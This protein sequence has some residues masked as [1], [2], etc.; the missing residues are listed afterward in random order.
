[1]R[2]AALAVAQGRTVFSRFMLVSALALLAVLATAQVTRAQGVFGGMDEG[3][4]RGDRAA[5]PVGAVVGG[6]VGGAVGG[7]NGVLGIN[8][9]YHRH[10]YHRHHHHY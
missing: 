9:R 3:A 4:R 6:A 7:V 10:H 8:P 5:G 2:S 1:M